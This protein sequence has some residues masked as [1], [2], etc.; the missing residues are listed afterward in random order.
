MLKYT[1]HL[2]LIFVVYNIIYKYKSVLGYSLFVK[3]RML[4]KIEEL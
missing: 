1:Y 2:I 3:L 4:K